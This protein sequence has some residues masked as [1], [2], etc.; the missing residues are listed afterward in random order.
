MQKGGEIEREGGRLL[1]VPP[2][3]TAPIERCNVQ[4]RKAHP[5]T[6]DE[7]VLRSSAVGNSGE[8]NDEAESVNSGSM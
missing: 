7:T 3:P 2:V 4:M 1:I 6:H 5:R 8:R